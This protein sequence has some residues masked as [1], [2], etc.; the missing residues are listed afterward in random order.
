[1]NRACGG[2]DGG[3][4]QVAMLDMRDKSSRCP[5]GLERVHPGRKLC[6]EAL[7]LVA[8]KFSSMIIMSHMIRCAKNNCLSSR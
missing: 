2:F 5:Q 3:W 8:H 6:V 7:I 4:M 1:M